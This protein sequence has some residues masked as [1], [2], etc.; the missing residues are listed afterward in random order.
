[1]SHEQ[2]IISS[3]EKAILL[4]LHRSLKDKRYADRIK[5][6][7]MI[8]NGYTHQETA[9]VLLLDQD[10]ITKCIKKYFNKGVEALISDNFVEYSGKLTS[11]QEKELTMTLESNL[12][13]T[14]AEIANYIKQVY[15]IEY[16]HDGMVKLL[17]RLGFVY[18]K[19]KA[20][21]SKANG[22]EQEK[23]IKEYESIRK[24][25]K[26][27]EKIY[28]LDA[29]HPVHNNTPDYA[30]IK[31]GQEKEVKTNTGRDRLNING[32]YSPID[33]ETIIRT[34]ETVNAQSTLEL[35]LSI[36][37]KHPHLKRI[38]IFS[39]NARYYH[40]KFLKENLPISIEFKYL[41]P[42]SP[43]LNLIERLWKLFR[44][45][46]MNNQYYE[47]FAEFKKAAANFFRSLRGRKKQL[48][49]LLSENFHVFNSA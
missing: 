47:T 30:W 32:L 21:P 27:K 38:I 8:S 33:H 13:S 29:M 25:L 16:S 9:N 4:K 18:K 11:D 45:D 46:V 2:I 12:F 28:F 35:L 34:S 23:F 1:M 39:D 41:P 3:E 40:A 20:V 17:H 48:S 19:T 6:V 49:K 15:H 31:K 7:L 5:A 26:N 24:S 22:K 10:T 36:T 37:N 14:A 42:Y 43:N 44:K